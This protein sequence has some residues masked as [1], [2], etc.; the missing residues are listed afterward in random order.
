M[1]IIHYSK[2]TNSNLIYKFLALW[3]FPG[4]YFSAILIN[5]PEEFLVAIGQLI[6]WINIIAALIIIA[7]GLKG[8]LFLPIVTFLLIS[9]KLARVFTNSEIIELFYITVLNVIICIVGSIIICQ[10]PKI[11]YKQVSII[12]ILNLLLMFLQVVGVGAWTQILTTYSEDKNANPIDTLFIQEVDLIYRLEQLR[13]S[14]FSH[15]TVLLTL[16]LVFSLTL[17]YCSFSRKSNWMTPILCALVV[18]SMGKMVFGIFL[19]LIIYYFLFGSKKEYITAKFS[20]LYFII[21]IVI[22]LILF[23]GLFAI[24]LSVDTLLSSFLIRISDIVLTFNPSSSIFVNVHGYTTINAFNLDAG[25]N[26]SGFSVLVKNLESVV[27]FFSIFSI[28]YLY[29]FMKMHLFFPE[30]AKLASLTFIVVMILPF[31][32]SFWST[33]IYWFIVGVGILPIFYLF[34]PS[35]ILNMKRI[36]L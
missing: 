25:E 20:A 24:N 36:N 12:S 10:H 1:E 28:L 16:I 9:S 21:F 14:G 32:H 17:H 2:K 13:P 8:S 30:L 33:Q 35:F 5:Q 11:I 34:K 31:M 7:K 29:G 3:I 18:L 19:L 23:P 15:S 26:I 22:Y 4:L 6:G 27:F